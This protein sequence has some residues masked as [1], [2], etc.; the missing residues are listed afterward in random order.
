MLKLKITQTYFEEVSTIEAAAQ[1]VQA[2]VDRLNLCA[3]DFEDL[4]LY[5]EQ[6]QYLGRFSYNG[7]FWP[8]GGCANE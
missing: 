7:R 2:Y 5:N 6:G 8:K 1:E 3:S 4:E